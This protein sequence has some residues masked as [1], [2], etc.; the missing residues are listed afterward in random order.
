M[1]KV[2]RGTVESAVDVNTVVIDISHALP[3]KGWMSEEEL[4]W[5]AAQASRS[6]VCVEIGSYCGR[7][8]RV[9]GDHLP[10]DGCLY[11]IDSFKPFSCIPPVISTP[12][13]GEQ[14]Y[15]E[16]LSNMSDLLDAGKVTIH[17]TS[18]YHAATALSKKTS[19]VDFL[20]INGDHSYAA[21]AQDIALWLPLIKTGGVISGHDYHIYPGVDQ[22]VDERFGSAVVNTMGSIWSV[23]L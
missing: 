9:I 19:W 14:V 22:A 12:E 21:V 4:L 20:F 15:A 16:F 1:A 11:C 3:I 18:S 2:A 13:E 6:L 8:S 17:R 7:S 10:K 23:Q 5:L